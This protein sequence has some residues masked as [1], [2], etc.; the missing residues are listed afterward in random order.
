MG[1]VLIC[2]SFNGT[3][4]TGV[5]CTSDELA[6][7]VIDAP[8]EALVSVPSQLSVVGFNDLP[9]AA[10][11]DP[12]LTT[13]RQPLVEKGKEAARLAYEHGSG[14]RAG[15]VHLDAKLVVRGS[16]A[17]PQRLAIAVLT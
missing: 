13:M 16:T 1:P 6:L 15:S 3:T 8:L 5:L 4:H 14:R 10:H 9:A 12:P 2:N 11:R 17:A 7:G